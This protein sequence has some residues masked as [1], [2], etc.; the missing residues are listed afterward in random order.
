MA[1]GIVCGFLLSDLMHWY[2]KQCAEIQRPR[3]ARFESAKADAEFQYRM[4]CAKQIEY[5][6]FRNRE[7]ERIE[8]LPWP[9]RIIAKSKFEGEGLRLNKIRAGE[10]DRRRAFI[11][12]KHDKWGAITRFFEADLHD[13]E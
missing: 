6:W 12:Y 8:A 13:G 5:T 10:R 2:R 11:M 1:S 3:T 7:S 4:D 9:E